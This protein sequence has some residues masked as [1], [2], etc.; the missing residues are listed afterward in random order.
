MQDLFNGSIRIHVRNKLEDKL[1]AWIAEAL[2]I[3]SIKIEVLETVNAQ[4]DKLCSVALP[5]LGIPVSAILCE[6]IKTGIV[7][8][9]E[10]TCTGTLDPDG[11][12]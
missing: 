10:D 4:I 7:D 6:D 8:L 2:G 3:D 5:A 12:H 1:G 11:E 9:I